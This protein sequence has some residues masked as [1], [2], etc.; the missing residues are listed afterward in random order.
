[1]IC[2][3]AANAIAAIATGSVVKL[4]GRIPVMVFAFTLHLAIIIAL[5]GWRP[6]PEQGILFFLM[7]GLW[8]VCDAIWLVQVNGMYYLLFQCIVYYLN[9]SA[10]ILFILYH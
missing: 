5:L 4:T 9:I 1:M 2:Y 3:G 6:T 7:S 8:G 10:S